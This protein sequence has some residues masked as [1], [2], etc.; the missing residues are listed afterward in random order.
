MSTRAGF[1][2]AWA[3]GTVVWLGAVTFVSIQAISQQVAESKWIFVPRDP[4]M[5]QPYF[6]PRS[7]ID[8]GRVVSMP[9]G[10]ELYFHRSIEQYWDNQDIGAI[11]ED[12]WAQRW[13][14][15][16]IYIRPWMLLLALPGFLFILVYAVLWVFDGFGSAAA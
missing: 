13:I 2:R 4:R 10:S 7:D 16:W 6:N 1:F 5:Y 9:D 12:F 14:R 3:V 8:N 15:Y 11:V